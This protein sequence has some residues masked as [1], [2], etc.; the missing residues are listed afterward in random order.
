MKAIDTIWD[1]A[2]LCTAAGQ[3]SLSI[4]T[5]LRL[6]LL[7][8]LVCGARLAVAQGTVYSVPWFTIDGG[9]G[10]GASADG[11]FSL[12]STIGQPDAGVHVGGRFTLEGGYSILAG[13]SIP[14]PPPILSIRNQNGGITLSWP[15]NYTG[16]T[17]QYTID[18]PSPPARPIWLPVTPQ[19]VGNTYFTQAFGNV[20]YFRLCAQ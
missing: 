7:S 9:G 1:F 16:F 5:L 3:R 4:R 11:R 19:P 14:I 17:L 12:Q 2:A 13:P 18:L 10:F 20:R 8:A 15:A 6:L